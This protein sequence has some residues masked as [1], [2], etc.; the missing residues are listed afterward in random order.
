M[1][2]QIPKY[3]NAGKYEPW[4]CAL[5]KDNVPPLDPHADKLFREARSLQT[6]KPYLSDGEKYT[7][8][9][10]YQ[11]SAELNHWRAMV[12]LANCY[13]AGEGTTPSITTANKI[14]DQMIE[15]NIPAGYY[16]KYAMVLHGRG[17]K[18]DA[19][20]AD[21]L[22]HKAADLGNPAAQYKLGVYYMYKEHRDKQGLR[23]LVCAARQGHGQAAYDIGYY[24]LI[25]EY[26]YLMVAEYF[27]LAATLGDSGAIGALKVAFGKSSHSGGP[28]QSLGFTADKALSKR[29]SERLR[30]VVDNPQMKF[31]NLFVEDPIPN[32]PLMSKE[33]SRAMKSLLRMDDGRWP[34][35]V[36]PE[37]APG[38]VVPRY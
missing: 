9:T 10:L 24:L 23:Y 25:E 5:E 28:R 15:R 34:D 11:Q 32:N 4:A 19:E 7:I 3:I 20:L 17:V 14:Y 21:E 30:A 13:I 12:N 37:L 1:G 22:L 33:Q 16:G 38:Y 27:W 35:E 2:F 31:P 6:S 8:F 18:A 26:N 29:F 36:F